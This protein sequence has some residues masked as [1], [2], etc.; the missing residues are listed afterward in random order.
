MITARRSDHRT[1]SVRPLDRRHVTIS[2]SKET[3]AVPCCNVTGCNVACRSKRRRKENR[4]I[5]GSVLCTPAA[6]QF[7]SGVQHARDLA[8]HDPGFEG[9]SR[10][11]DPFCLLLEAGNATA[12]TLGLEPAA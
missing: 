12:P 6:A 11:C 5:L 9:M 4:L 10:A 1:D 7:P 3:V 2:S 8:C